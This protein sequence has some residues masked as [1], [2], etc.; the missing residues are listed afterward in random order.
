MITG[1]E[2]KAMW[3]KTMSEKNAHIAAHEL[4]QLYQ[5]YDIAFEKIS[6]KKGMSII[7][8]GCGGGFM[9][10]YI[11]D[12]YPGVKYVA[13][14]ISERSIAAARKTLK[15]IPGIEIIQIDPFEFPQLKAD[16]LISLSVIQHF[17]TEEYLIKFLNWL[18]EMK[19]TNLVL[20][21]RYA[22]TTVFQAKPYETERS[23]IHACYTNDAYLKARL[24][25]YVLINKSELYKNQYQYLTFKQKRDRV[26]A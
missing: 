9:G 19:Y 13:L 11:A 3:N 24:N 15:G 20:Q 21:I 22:E 5:V 16:F 1:A 4:W 2:Y 14:D 23:V 8:F 10:K 18:N 6:V 17:P 25:N 7:D 26:N 12:K